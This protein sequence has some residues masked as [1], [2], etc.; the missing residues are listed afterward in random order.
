MAKQATKAAAV[1][2]KRVAN[3]VMNVAI[4]CNTMANAN[5][6]AKDVTVDLALNI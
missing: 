5:G 1:M 3:I 4:C 6:L 2:T